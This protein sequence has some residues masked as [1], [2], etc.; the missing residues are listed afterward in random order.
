MTVRG[1]V[2]QLNR[3]LDVLHIGPEAFRESLSPESIGVNTPS[4][5]GRR[6]RWGLWVPPLNRPRPIVHPSSPSTSRGA[7]LLQAAALVCGLVHWSREH[8]PTVPNHLARSL[9]WD[10][11]KESAG[12]DHSVSDECPCGRTPEMVAFCP[13]RSSEPPRMNFNGEGLEATLSAPLLTAVVG[14]VN[15]HHDHSPPAFGL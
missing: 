8:V 13:H 14:C 6:L 3:I 10:N 4:Q 12:R 9:L 7:Q 2:P 1:I 15:G 5:S 11:S